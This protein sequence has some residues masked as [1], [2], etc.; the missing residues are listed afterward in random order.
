MSRIEPLTIEELTPQQQ[1]M[2]AQ[3]ERLMGFVSNDTLVMARNP[4]LME[5]FARLV[6]EIYAPGKVE[7]GLKRLIGLLTSAAAGCTYCVAHTAFS[8][9]RQGVETERLA[10]VWEFEDSDLFSVAEK[11]ALRVAFHAGQVPYA[12]SDTMF[13]ELATH[14]DENAQIEIVSVIAMFGFLNRWNA[15]LATDLEE[16]PYAALEDVCNALEEQV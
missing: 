16:L 15:T 13:K 2:V 3:A 11:A 7:A 5:T 12:V 6:E 4:A 10:A 1:D 8:S 9:T 14:F